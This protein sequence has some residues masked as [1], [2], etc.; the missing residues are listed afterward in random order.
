MRTSCVQFNPLFGI[1]DVMCLQNST[2]F[3][4]LCYI[5]CGLAILFATKIREPSCPTSHSS[6]GSR[7]GSSVFLN[8]NKI[9]QQLPTVP[10]LLNKHKSKTVGEGSGF[11]APRT[12][13]IGSTS[14]LYASGISKN[15][16][17]ICNWK[18]SILR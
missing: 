14:Q 11:R 18:C 2:K 12:Q 5:V 1:S 17:P 15:V 4:W 7:R 6:G 10:R 8:K 16:A 3:R 13:T 9:V